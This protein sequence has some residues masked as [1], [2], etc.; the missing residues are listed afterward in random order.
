ML[1]VSRAL[2]LSPARMKLTLL[3]LFILLL[4]TACG[5]GNKTPK[6]D[7]SVLLNN[8]IIQFNGLTYKTVVSPYTG[9]TWLDRNL[10]ASEACSAADDSACFGDYYQWGRNADG[11]EKSTSNTTTVQATDIKDVGHGDFI[12]PDVDSLITGIGGSITD[13]NDHD[14]AKTIDADG[15]KRHLN[16]MDIAGESICPTGYHVPTLEELEAETTK[17]FHAVT[18]LSSAFDNFLKL[19]AAGA[20]LIND[21]GYGQASEAKMSSVGEVGNI[22]SSS[23]DGDDA[24]HSVALAFGQTLA[25][26]SVYRE[27][28]APV[29][30][31]S[32]RPLEHVYPIADAGSSRTANTGAEVVLDASASFN[33]QGDTLHYSWRIDTRPDASQAALSGSDTANPAFIAD[34][35][36]EY[37][38]TLVLNAG[39]EHESSSSVSVLARTTTIHFQGVGYTTVVSPYTGRVWLDRNLGASAFCGRFD[40]PD[41]YGDYYQWGRSADGHQKPDS[42]TSTEQSLF[43]LVVQHSNFIL[44]TEA[45]VGDWAYAADAYGAQRSAYWSSMGEGNICPAG[46]RVPSATELRQE[47]YDS[48]DGMS[49]EGHNNRQQAFENFLRLPAAG[50]RSEVN[51]EMMLQGQ[52]GGLWSSTAF[53]THSVGIHFGGYPDEWYAEPYYRADGYPV[54]CIKDSNTPIDETPPTAV[55]EV[56]DSQGQ[57]LANNQIDEGQ[58]FI[59]SGHRSSDPDNGSIDHYYWRALSAG[60]QIGGFAGGQEVVTTSDSLAINDPVAAGLQRYQLIVDDQSGN[61]SAAAEISIVIRAVDTEAPTAVL[62]LTDSNGQAISNGRVEFGDD[63]YLSAQGSSDAGGG[64][65][66]LYH[67][68]ALSSAAQVGQFS[69]GVEVVGNQPSLHIDASVT[70]VATGLQSYQLL[71]EDNSGNLSAAVQAQV[72]V[73][74]SVAP[75]AVLNFLNSNGQ[76]VSQLDQGQDFILSGQ[77]SS[78]ANGGSIAHYHWSA[79]TTGAQVGVFSGGQEVV[80]ESNTLTVTDVVAAGA[81]TWRLVVEDLS[82]NLSAPDDIQI[83]IN[84]VSDVVLSPASPRVLLGDSMALT[85]MVSGLSDDTLSWAVNGVAGGNSTLGTVDGTGVYSAPALMPTNSTVTVTATSVADAAV[86]DAVSIQLVDPH[87]AGLYAAYSTGSSYLEAPIVNG[88]SSDCSSTSNNI[89]QNQCTDP[90]SSPVDWAWGNFNV[91]WTGYLHAPA[92]G[93]YGISSYYWVDGAVTVDIDGQVIADFDT[94]GGGYSGSIDLVA[95]ERVPVTLSFTSNGGSNNMSLFWTPP[96]QSASPIPRA[97]LEPDQIPA[98]NGCV[99]PCGRGPVAGAEVRI[100]RLK[101]NGDKTLLFSETTTIGDLSTAGQFDAHVTYLQDDSW[102]L[103]EMS[104]GEDFDADRDGVLDTVASPNLGTLHLFAKGSDL[105]QQSKVNV[106]MASDILYHKF[107]CRLYSAPDAITPADLNS[108]IGK[109][110]A[111]DVNHDASID[112][113]D[114]LSFEAATDSGKLSPVYQRKQTEILTAILADDRFYYSGGLDYLGKLGFVPANLDFSPDSSLAYSVGGNQLKIIDISDP[115]TMNVVA[116]LDVTGAKDVAVSSDGNTV[117]IVGDN[118]LQLIDVSSPATPSINDDN[119]IG[120]GNL[121]A[122]AI[123]N[124]GDTLFVASN[125][126]NTLSIIDLTASS[127]S[128]SGSL[129]LNSAGSAFHNMVVSTNDSRLF[130]ASNT[131]YVIDVADISAPSELASQT[132]SNNDLHKIALSADESTAYV[133]RYHALDVLDVSNAVGGVITTVSSHDMTYDFYWPGSVAVHGDTLYAMN[134]SHGLLVYDISSP[135]QLQQIDRNISFGFN[136]G[137]ME[138]TPDGALLFAGDFKA[139]DTRDVEGHPIAGRYIRASQVDAVAISADNSL[140]YILDNHNAKLQVI[141]ISDATNLTVNRVLGELSGISGSQIILNAVGDR[142]FIARGSSGFDIIDIT[143]PTALSVVT[144]YDTTGSVGGLLLDEGNHRL[145]LADG[146]SGIKII[147]ITDELNPAEVGSL[148]TAGTA[149]DVALSPDHNMLYAAARESG[150]QVIDITDETVPQFLTTFSEKTF[151]ARSL[152]LSADGSKLFVGGGGTSAPSGFAMLDVSTPASPALLASI[153]TTDTR[154]I[155]LSA[156]ETRAYIADGAIASG[157]LKIIDI[158]DPIDVHIVGGIVDQSFAHAG[159]RLALSSDGSQIYLADGQADLMV[160]N[161]CE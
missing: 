148:D 37:V 35:D 63:F 31:I 78:D 103:Y 25:V 66:V 67:W 90:N 123:A 18:D 137:P 104:G 70:P 11:H 13:P 46:F 59:L 26:V 119:S 10:G 75:T 116:T 52:Y 69:G 8:N 86:S 17:A 117:Y 76:L 45:Y 129:P 139:F 15:A 64:S 150:V 2:I 21:P 5:G 23:V 48:A 41:C 94:T 40:D 36:G 62:S 19:P 161:I 95:G 105:K 54:R 138:L 113:A 136:Y 61:L 128:V 144:N 100:S 153:S 82:G 131:F 32:T 135:T 122:V 124:S 84:A 159:L 127:L 152:K 141:D 157:N 109:V 55:L 22:W 44:S 96:G 126:S 68:Q 99:A 38:L 4:L 156:D 33:P 154:D 73:Q 102:Y 125:A 97:Y 93:S 160:I 16:W 72:I 143:D 155:V 20:R 71:A 29:R 58:G 112:M 140:A 132:Y 88:W 6:A 57:N 28:G 3:W 24:S 34:V 147:N 130:I 7:N 120:L 27:Y 12:I 9:K 107:R 53:S 111:Q 49:T 87:T 47:T 98:N 133:V 142:A 92:T 89:Y 65:I 151:Y 101:S 115:Q 30:C 81:Q 42:N 146:T 149:Y 158:S 60:A 80:T 50:Y 77:T 118:G 145:Y 106:T 108:A 110:L 56:T 43:A 85:A 14:W 74:D 91:F 1:N 114:I 51:G 134:V 39:S 121:S 79:V 83:I